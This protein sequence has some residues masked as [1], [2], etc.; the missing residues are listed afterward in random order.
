LTVVRLT[1]GEAIDAPR[2]EEDPII[3]TSLRWTTAA[4]G[5]AAGSYAAYVA[6]TWSRYGQVARPDARERDELLDRFMP[7]YEVVERHHIHV[8]APAAATLAAACDMDLFAIPAVR[9][10]IRARELLLGARRTSRTR[11]TGLLA[12]MQSLGWVVLAEVPD[13]EIVVGAVTQPWE[14]N[15][16]FHS[17]PPTEFAGFSTPDYVKIVW[18]LRADPVDATSAVFR[19]ET[20]VCTT[21]SLARAKFRRYWSWISPGIVLIRLLMLRALKQRAESHPKA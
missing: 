1:I 14:A 4:L 19:T 11:P 3:R 16:T 6:V 10:I 20:R 15:V 5:A 13:R 7:T 2:N 12:E 18:T 17:I 21:N 9:G 8:A